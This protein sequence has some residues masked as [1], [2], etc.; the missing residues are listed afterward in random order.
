LLPALHPLKHSQV[1]TGIRTVPYYSR[2]NTIS[3]FAG[4]WQS[5]GTWKLVS[6]HILGVTTQPGGTWKHASK[7]ILEVTTQPAKK[8][9]IT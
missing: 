5:G 1:S 2:N 8:E 3:R 9:S 4:N 6:K 7:H